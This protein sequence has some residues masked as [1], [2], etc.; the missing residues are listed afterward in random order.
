[1]GC[2]VFDTVE[3]AVRET[4]ATATMIFVPPGLAGD[5]DFW[6]RRAR[7]STFDLR[8]YGRRFLFKT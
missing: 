3:R 7:V 6:R 8:H 5:C 2:P 4:G 1:M